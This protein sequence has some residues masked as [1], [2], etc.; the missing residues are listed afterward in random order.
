MNLK[1]DFF[2]LKIDLIFFCDLRFFLITSIIISTVAL[3]NLFERTLFR[4]E[5]V[6]FNDDKISID[7]GN[8]NNDWQIY[9]TNI[10]IWGTKASAIFRFD[11][12]FEYRGSIN[13]TVILLL[14]VRSGPLMT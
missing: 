3:L 1:L 14:K 13:L 4:S 6:I 12:T 10:D 5:R 2:N 9:N 7:C 8:N 11:K